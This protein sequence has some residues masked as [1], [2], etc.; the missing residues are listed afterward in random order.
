V[1]G[2]SAWICGS[3]TAGSS[4]VWTAANAASGWPRYRLW[5][6]ARRRLARRNGQP[7]GW[8][9]LLQTWPRSCRV[10]CSFS[11]R[12]YDDRPCGWRGLRLMQPKP[13]W[14]TRAPPFPSLWLMAAAATPVCESASS[15]Q[16]YAWR[17]PASMWRRLLGA[18]R[19]GPSQ[20]S[21]CQI[22]VRVDGH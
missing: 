13:C 11:V 6:V 18:G 7:C 1:V 12:L 20:A 10:A 8:R 2:L 19:R 9:E 5:W 3:A 16:I 14:A 15:S 22:W 17:G 21:L 4:A